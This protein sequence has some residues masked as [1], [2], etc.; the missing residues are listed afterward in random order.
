MT[1]DV[2]GSN[3]FLIIIVLFFFFMLFAG[4]NGFGWGGNRAG[5]FLAS[6]AYGNGFGW[7]NQAILSAVCNSEKQ[8]I[9]NSARTQYL[10]EQQAAETR[11]YIGNKIDFYEYQ[12]LR[13]RANA[14]EQR[15]MFL[16]GQITDIQ[17]YNLL[18][19]Q[20][21]EINCNM[22]KTP[23]VYGVGTVCQGSLVPNNLCP[24]TTTTTPTA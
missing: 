1:D 15:N 19:N 5:A 17:R 18:Q 7:N 8:E 10:V 14:A 22:L 20:I 6:E 23:K 12:N 16:E 13:D 4:G 3:V 11:N 2:T 9:I 21:A 24:T